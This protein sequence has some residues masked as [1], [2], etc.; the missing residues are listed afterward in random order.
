MKNAVLLHGTGAHSRSNWFP[1]LKEELEKEGWI[2]WVP[3]LPGAE[4]P[5]IERYNTFL[6]SSDW[7]FNKDTVLVGHSSGSVAILGLL[8]ALPED[9]T[10]QGAVLVGSFRNDLKWDS[11]KDLFVR[12]FDFEKIKQK[13]KKFVFVHS[14]DDPICPVDQAEYLC[15]KVGG[16][17]ILVSGRQH[18][19]VGYGGE[20][21]RKVPEI[22]AAVQ[23]IV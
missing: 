8:E 5:N 15:G 23:K 14:S 16:E 17:F 4:K 7:D 18:F 3:D 22:L 2:V 6:L 11:L 21:N 20:Q 9:T 12:P 10:I 1:W 19:S 13:A